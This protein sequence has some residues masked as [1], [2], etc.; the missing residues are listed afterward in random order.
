M[1]LTNT[2]DFPQERIRE[3]IGFIK[4]NNLIAPKYTIR[5][6]NSNGPTGGHFA[7]GSL[8]IHISL[9]N[10]ECPYPRRCNHDA[11]IRRP[12]RQITFK[13]QKFNEKKQIWEWWRY[14][15]K[16]ESIKDVPKLFYSGYISSL[17]LSREESLVHVLSHEMRHYWQINHPGKR[18]KIWGAKGKFSERD[19][20]A[21][22]IRMTRAWRR[23]HNKPQIINWNIFE[24]ESF[25][26]EKEN[27]EE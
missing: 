20:D 2:T 7:P 6:T 25:K 26:K 13:F 11:V 18:G 1:K 19:A 3:I 16:Y 27:E 9:A 17:E 4:P 14:T 23:L 12:Q 22:A 5:I 10:S 21:Y 24:E 8:Y 15:K